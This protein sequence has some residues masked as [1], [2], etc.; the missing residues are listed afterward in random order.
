MLP[1]LPPAQEQILATLTCPSAPSSTA[2]ST[3]SS[4]ARTT[5]RRSSNGRNAAVTQNA[6][7]RILRR[8]LTA[9]HRSSPRHISTCRSARP[10]HGRRARAARPARVT[11]EAHPM[12]TCDR[13]RRG[14]P[15]SMRVPPPA[16]DEPPFDGDLP[17]RR[18]G[19]ASAALPGG[20]RGHRLD[21]GHGGRHRPVSATAMPEVTR[22]VAPVP[23]LRA[24][25]GRKRGRRLAT[26]RPRSAVAASRPPAWIW[27]WGAMPR[28]SSSRS[29][30]TAPSWRPRRLSCGRLGGRSASVAT[31]AE[32]RKA[33]G[34]HVTAEYRCG[35][36][37]DRL[38]RGR[39]AVVPGDIPCISGLAADV[40]TI[41]MFARMPEAGRVG[42]GRPRPVPAMR[43]ASRAS[44]A[45]D[46]SETATFL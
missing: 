43:P 4:G 28:S 29:S 45:G 30:A 20:V 23:C 32:H 41:P 14:D 21:A 27:T 11:R 7:L 33:L 17:E 5:G 6:P 9:R 13:I 12:A 36:R 15:A 44:G 19:A 37:G 24:T 46:G 1:R 34:A 26:C 39:A 38:S 35:S 10:R 25:R 31:R 18:I 8:W 2:C 3:S 16:S 22:S 42:G 40:A